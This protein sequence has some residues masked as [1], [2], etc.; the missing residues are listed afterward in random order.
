VAAGDQL[1]NVTAR[2]TRA[3]GTA[4]DAPPRD[5][6][7]IGVRKRLKR[8][9]AVTFVVL[10]TAGGHV[11]NV[12]AAL[13]QGLPAPGALTPG[14]PAWV[15]VSV[16][17]VWIHPTSPR[18]LDGPALTDPARIGTWLGSMTVTGRLGLHGRIDTQ[19]VYGRKV[20]ILSESGKWSRVAIPSQ[21]G[22]HF[23][24]GV[25]GWVPSAQL[26]T[27][28]PP[29]TTHAVVVSVPSA[30]LYSESRGMVGGR[31]LLLSYATEL[32]ELSVSHGY[33]FVGLPGG[34]EG[35]LAEDTVAPVDAAPVPGSA[36]VSQARL[37][38]G[39]PYLWGGTSG[40]G[41]DCSGLVYS[42]FARYGIMLP[43]NAADQRRATMPIPLGQARAG[44]LLF[45]A[46]P[47][48]AGE[49]D[50]VAIYAGDGLMVDAPYTGALVEEVP[51]RTSFGWP[52]FAGVGRVRGIG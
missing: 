18:P 1:A 22:N 35:A 14:V 6:G 42:V 31:R 19:M 11:A 27:A 17:T 37:F 33:A 23:P 32:P 45:F 39:L 52:D 29:A 5:T 2:E 4:V 25:I 30:W 49:V 20:V 40:F 16:A 28:G 9:A 7:S 47:H 48:G 38:I 51:M 41:Y 26:D 50:H 36:I 10:T 44:D 3:L 13:G 8:V 34:G 46:G 21:T 15:Q 24:N 43:R 12:A